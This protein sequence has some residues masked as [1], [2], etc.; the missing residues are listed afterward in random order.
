M[1]LVFPLCVYRV[2][3]SSSPRAR[4]ECL[5]ICLGAY[6]PSPQNRSGNS[7]EHQVSSGDYPLIPHSRG[8]VVR[9]GRVAFR[10]FLCAFEF[11][12]DLETWARHIGSLRKSRKYAPERMVLAKFSA[13]EK[14][15]GSEKRGASNFARQRVIIVNTQFAARCSRTKRA[16]LIKRRAD[17][18]ADIALSD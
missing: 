4:G 16:A 5:D 13:W 2:S 18:T 14:S 8:S 15:R 12:F 11:R 9:A 1:S 10:N 7:H 3:S 6:F 17:K